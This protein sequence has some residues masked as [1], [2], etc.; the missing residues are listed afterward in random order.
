MMF[1]TSARP[2]VWYRLNKFWT[3]WGL[4]IKLIGMILWSFKNNLLVYKLTSCE[5]ENI[6]LAERESSSEDSSESSWVILLRLGMLLESGLSSSGS[7]SLRSR[8]STERLRTPQLKLSMVSPCDTERPGV[9][10]YR[11][12][13]HHFTFNTLA[14]T[15]TGY[16]DSHN[17]AV[18][19][20]YRAW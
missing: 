3:Y 1:S 15:H 8:L 16:K 6:W 5:L 19:F 4:Q 20:S 9:N 17:H 11:G 10:H 14:R 12:L 18:L 13:K 7:R 2:R